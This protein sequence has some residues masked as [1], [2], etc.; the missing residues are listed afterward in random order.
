MG[1]LRAGVLY[2]AKVEYDLAE[3]QNSWLMIKRKNLLIYVKIKFV[4][5]VGKF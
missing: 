1:G 3:I 4:C 2:G 5:L